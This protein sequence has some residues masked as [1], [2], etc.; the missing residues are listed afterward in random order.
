MMLR[1]QILQALSGNVCVNG[2]GRNIGMPKQDLN[3]P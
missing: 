2:G 3:R 1:M